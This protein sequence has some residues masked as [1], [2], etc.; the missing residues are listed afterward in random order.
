MVSLNIGRIKQ[1]WGMRITL[2]LLFVPVLVV[3]LVVAFTRA[4]F[5]VIRETTADAIRVWKEAGRWRLK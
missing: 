4:F 3:N 1:R 5:P 2:V